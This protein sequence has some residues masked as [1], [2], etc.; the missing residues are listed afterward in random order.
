MN[1]LANMDSSS[2]ATLSVQFFPVDPFKID[3]HDS[4]LRLLPANMATFTS[5]TNF[6]STHEPRFEYVILHGQYSAHTTDKPVEAVCKILLCRNDNALAGLRHEARLY[7][8]ELSGLQGCVVPR[9]F[10]YYEGTAPKTQYGPAYATACL[11]LED[12]GS[13]VTGNDLSTEAIR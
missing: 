5:Q 4:S 7:R 6:P 2:D 9:M 3:A 1:F 10:E 11:I 8:R 12:C 13:F